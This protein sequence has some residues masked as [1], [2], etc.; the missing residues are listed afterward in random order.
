MEASVD[1]GIEISSCA[2]YQVRPALYKWGVG[3]CS[4]EALQDVLRLGCAQPQRGCI[5]HEACESGD[6]GLAAHGSRSPGGLR[7]RH[8]DCRRR[9]KPQDDTSQ[10]GKNITTL[11]LLRI[12]FLTWVTSIEHYWVTLRERRGHQGRTKPQPA[13][14]LKPLLDKMKATLGDRVKDVRASVRLS[15][16]CSKRAFISLFGSRN[17]GR[18]QRAL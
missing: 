6:A 11:C 14:T 5:L 16:T 9:C 8:R 15:D 13:E 12:L 18:R 7:G 10:G 3:R 4:G 17:W 1:S 2:L